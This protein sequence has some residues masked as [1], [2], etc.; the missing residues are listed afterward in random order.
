MYILI[1]RAVMSVR[2]KHPDHSVVS[3]LA[4]IEVAHCAISIFPID[5]NGQGLQQFTDLEL[6][7][8]YQ[9]T[10]GH[11]FEGFSRL[12]LVEIVLDAV[13]RLPVSKVK[14]FEAQQQAAKIAFT[15]Q[16]FYRYTPGAYVANRQGD[17]FEPPALTVLPGA[18]LDVA[19]VQAPAIVQ[20]CTKTPIAAPQ[21]TQP[22]PTWHPAYR[23]A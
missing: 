21:F 20:E 6:K 12:H 11:K 9:N 3:N 15:D 14:A 10:T 5:D 17:L 4:T 2:H 18:A 16:G 19:A 22:L 23:G 8:L 1:D 7:L 13:R